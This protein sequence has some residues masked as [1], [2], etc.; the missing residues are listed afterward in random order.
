MQQSFKSA[1][2]DLNDDANTKALHAY[3]LTGRA[4]FMHRLQL[5]RVSFLLPAAPPALVT[6][7][8]APG[9]GG[10]AGVPAAAERHRARPLQVYRSQGHR[11]R[12]PLEKI[13]SGI[14]FF[15]QQESML[16]EHIPASKLI[17]L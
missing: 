6:P 11:P 8:A 12:G 5:L 2:M 15:E 4:R 10:G 17:I 7:P 14:H 1:F 16:F 13:T 3:T 9:A